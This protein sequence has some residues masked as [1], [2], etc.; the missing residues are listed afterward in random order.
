ME[1]TM[2]KTYIEDVDRGV[3]DLKNADEYAYKTNA[4]LTKEIILEISI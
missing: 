3:Y 2:K 4:G 1:Q